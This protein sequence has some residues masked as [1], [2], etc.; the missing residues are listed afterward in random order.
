MI[1]GRMWWR[2]FPWN[3]A[4]ADG[5]PFS[6]RYVPPAGSQ[7]GGRF[8]LGTP[9]ITYLASRPEHAVAEV[10]QE[11]RGK[12]LKDGHLL[13]A[14]PFTPGVYHRLTLVETR[15]PGDIEHR[16]LDL[17]NGGVL[18]R[19]QLRPSDLASHERTRTQPIA[20]RIHGDPSGYTGFRW[21]SAL[22]GEWNSGVLFLD[23]MDV[24]LI[25][26]G[27]PDPLEVVHPVVQA[28]ARFLLML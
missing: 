27:I 8:D 16:L 12:P 6:A 14:D 1:P 21:W 3:P 7:I 20:R 9:S 10:L 11:F 25:E 28:A 22:T 4:A 26:Y 19:L 23:R 2:V 17:D 15:L 13:R 18:E 5:A 24:G